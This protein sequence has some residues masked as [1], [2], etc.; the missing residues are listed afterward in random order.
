MSNRFD[1]GGVNLRAS[2]ESAVARPTSE[3]PFCI[4][5]LGDFSGRANRGLAEPKTIG[6]RPSY[7]VDRDNFDEVLSKLHPELHLPTGDKIPLVFRFSELE[8]F[9]PDRLFENEAFRKLKGLR[10]RVQ[11]SSAFADVAEEL[12]LRSASSARENESPRVSAPSPVRLASGS[13]LDE[14][15]EQTESRVALESTRKTDEVHQFARELAAKYSVSSPDPRQPDVVAAVD[16]AISDAMRV[17]LHH[18]D[19]QALEAIW[20]STFLLVRQIETGPQL[21]IYLIDISKQELAA[22]LKASEDHR[23]SGIFRLLVEKA[24]DTPGADPW[25]VVVGNFSF[26][27]ESEDTELLAKLAAIAQRAGAAFLGEADPSLLG[28]ASLEAA[29]H[30]RDWNEST[31]PNPWKQVRLR[32]ESGSVALALP[33]F[34]LRLPYGRETSPLESFEFEEFSGLPL[35]N[36]YLWGNPAFAVGMLL[37]QSFNEAG[38]GLRLGSLSQVENLPLHTYRADGGSHLKPCA[39]VLLTEE[40]VER[41]LDCG[42]IPL[43]SYK[44]RDSVRVGRFQSIAEPQRPLAGRWQ[45]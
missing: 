25:T 29:P 40:A 11:D 28:C 39:E 27:S 7:L 33:R 22:D 14:L 4:A 31:V 8:D 30:P 3:T 16:R 24:I 37:G 34:L 23:K 21:K 38:W 19:F 41:I 18:S 5:I 43:V 6:E 42:L 1:F 10:E 9:H 15:I 2:E 36:G 20:R 17:I 45:A 26:G 13:L 44:G 35:H 32:P 12:G